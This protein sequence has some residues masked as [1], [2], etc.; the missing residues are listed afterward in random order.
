MREDFSGNQKAFLKALVDSKFRL[1]ALKGSRI[2]W[3]ALPNGLS[4]GN[5]GSN[6]FGDAKG[7][8]GVNISKI[9]Y[10]FIFCSRHLSR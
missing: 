7:N 1:K 6:P 10:P 2:R 4:R 5:T 8:Q 9:G 3:N